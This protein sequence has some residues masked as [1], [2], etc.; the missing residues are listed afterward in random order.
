[1]EILEYSQD[2]H[3][4]TVREVAEHLVA[5]FDY[6]GGVAVFGKAGQPAWVVGG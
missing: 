1:L 2:H 4:A 3:P 5:S 6:E